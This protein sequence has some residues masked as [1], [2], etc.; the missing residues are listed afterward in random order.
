MNSRFAGLDR[1]IINV[2]TTC[3]PWFSRFSLFLVYFWFGI[4]KVVAESPANP[5]V[6]SLLEKTLPFMTFE[7]FIVL[8]G[9]FEV[10]I[11]I[12]FLLPKF[13]R[14]VI[15]LLTVHMITTVMPL[16]L[17]PQIAW[18][19]PFVPTLEGQYMIKNILI[20]ALAIGIVSHLHPMGSHDGKTA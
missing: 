11:G 6:S 19:A 1:A 13:T 17:L 14:V 9:V 3:S 10:L 16:I 7:T 5:L 2:C 18:S 15:P 8:L 4:L 12:L 20:I